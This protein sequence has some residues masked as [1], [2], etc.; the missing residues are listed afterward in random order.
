MSIPTLETYKS[1]IFPGNL[2][3]HVFSEKTHAKFSMYP[4]Q[5][6]YGT[7]IGVSL[8]RVLLS[9]IRGVAVS[10]IKITGITN[11][12]SAVPGI[13][14]D[15]LSIVANLRNVAF[16]MNASES[17]QL[18]I[19]VKPDSKITAANIDL[20]SNVTI[21]NPSAYLFTTSN[22]SSSLSIE[23]GL[24]AGIGNVIQDQSREKRSDVLHLD[25]FFSPVKNVAFS[26]TN[27]RSGETVDHDR[28]DIDIETNGTITPKDALGVAAT[29]F[30]QFLSVCVDFEEKRVVG[31]T[32]SS[33]LSSLGINDLLNRRVMELELSVRS[34]NCLASEGIKYI[35]QLVQRTENDIIRT[36]N[37]GR[38]SLE[39]I[40]VVL[41]AMGL[42][43]GMKMPDWTPPGSEDDDLDSQFE[44]KK[45]RGAK[46]K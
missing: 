21:A 7:T 41:I 34:A 1:L 27:A 11:E 19:D 18:K 2:E 30:R 9:S 10:Y 40:K 14:E 25:M 3:S 29:L 12:Y 8:R 13:K 15:V 45:L 4:I 32:S 28:L 44:G 23:I 35:G 31:I 26:V 36:P 16:I 5:K 24:Q 46:V 6:G 33:G 20:P 22:I 39:E 37:F 17:A 43:L 42:S 38:K